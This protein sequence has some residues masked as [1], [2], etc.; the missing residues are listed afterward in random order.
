MESSQIAGEFNFTNQLKFNLQD[1]T[2]QEDSGESSDEF[3]PENEFLTEEH[4]KLYSQLTQQE[5]FC[6]NEL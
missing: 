3:S 5:V 4:K 1:L 6:L 2:P